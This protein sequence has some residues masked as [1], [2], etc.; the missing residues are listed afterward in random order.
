VSVVGQFVAE[1]RGN[2]VE[3]LRAATSAN[4]ARLFNLPAR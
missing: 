4:S 3:M 1:L 2:D